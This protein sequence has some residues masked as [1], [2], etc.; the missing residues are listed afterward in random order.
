MWRFGPFE[1]YPSERR[2]RKSRVDVPLQPKTF[3]VL[4]TLVE[5]A[6]KLVSREELMAAVWGG[7]IVEDANLTNS[8]TMLRRKLGK[9]AIKTVSKSG[10]RFNLN[11]TSTTGISE[12]ADSLMQDGQAHMHERTTETVT[13]AKNSFLLAIAE[14]PEL[15]EAWA[16]LARASRYL[17]KGGLEPKS[18][19]QLAEAAFR[20]AFGIDPDL[21]SAH[22][23][24][25]NYQTDCGQVLDALKR[26]L[27]RVRKYPVEAQSYA[28]LVQVCRFCGLLDASMGAHKRALELDSSIETSIPHTHFA[29]CDYAAVVESYAV[30]GK[31]TVRGYLDAA[32]WASLGSQKRVAAEITNRL[33]ARSFPPLFEALLESLL[34]AI[35][36]DSAKVGEICLRQD[37]REDPESALYFARHLAWS[38][39][40]DPALAL[41]RQSLSGGFSVPD[42]LQ[43]DPWLAS[44]R[45]EHT[46][47]VILHE[48]I[49]RHECAKEIFRAE[50]GP[51]LLMPAGD[52]AQPR[53]PRALAGRKTK[54]TQRSD[55]RAQG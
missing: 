41:L 44:L 19:R 38:G 14:Q 2:L 34:Y 29:R 54:K 20:R 1:L 36:G 6:D 55:H 21:A 53:S 39:S 3:D 32:A 25:T 26:L 27:S 17:E 46:F 18:N 16:W 49:K 35:R 24:F 4:L 48:A 11:V 45:K 7:T 9:E 50:G 10:Y 28:G 23:F 22:Q 42:M 31:G 37:V 12:A 8:I 52:R 43:K 13:N 40:L 47:S 51:Q 5:N 30:I 33:A 15:A